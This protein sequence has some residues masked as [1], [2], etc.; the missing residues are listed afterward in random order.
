MPKKIDP[1]L[2]HS[3][4]TRDPAGGADQKPGVESPQRVFPGPDEGFEA[5][6]PLDSFEDLA[7][8]FEPIQPRVP[9]VIRATHEAWIPP[10]GVT[11]EAQMGRVFS[12]TV[13]QTELTQLAQDSEIQQIDASREVEPDELDVT[14]SGVK[15]DAVHHGPNGGERGDR[16][17]VGVIDSGFDV[18]HECFRDQHGNTR[19][20]EL[21]DQTDPTGPPPP[22]F[23]AGTHHTRADIQRYIATASVPSGLGRDPRGHGTHVASIAAGRACGSFA[24]GVAPEADLALVV[25]NII[26][27]PN[28]PRSIGYSTSHIAALS[29][30]DRVV[31]SH[32]KPLVVNVSQGMN[33]GAHDG[34]SSLETAFDWFITQKPGR[35]LIKS[36]GNERG[37]YGHVSLVVP[38]GAHAQVEW[39]SLGIPRPFDLIELWFSS[40]DDLSV[41]LRDPHGNAGPS[42][43]KGKT[44]DA[45]VLPTGERAELTYTAFHPDNGETQLMLILSAN[46]AA[47]MASGAWSLDIHNNGRTAAKIEGWVE[48][49]KRRP[50][51]FTGHVVDDRTL[52]IPGTANHVVA[53]AALDRAATATASYSSRGDTRDGRQRPDLCAP[54]NNVWAARSG[55]RSGTASM[56]GTSMATPHVSGAAALLLSKRD[57]QSKP[58]LTGR[59]VRG[60]L[61]ST[62]WPITAG[63]WNPDSGWGVLDIHK[64]LNLI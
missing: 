59:Q 31:T 47:S 30:L 44:A 35:A 37:K 38:P 25:S 24:G 9:V 33:A 46:T 12:A 7:P 16:A 1:F 8:D 42:V 5:A 19:I 41:E 26:Q 27:K 2:W 29:F 54:G 4:N 36:A 20:I 23:T 10:P 58:M 39:K 52:S 6:V 28:R 62:A 40:R 45:V 18:L 60:M 48:R 55:T 57:K 63:G 21:W 43:D 3:L 14:K 34:T 53:V 11:I 51:R 17:L 61:Q 50:V 49:R 32:G 13:T 15:A 64:L 56:S 22:G